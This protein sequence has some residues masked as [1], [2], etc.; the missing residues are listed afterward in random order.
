MSDLITDF[1]SYTDS[2]PS[3]RLF[4][5]WAGIALVAGALERRVWTLS[6]GMRVYPN[7]YTLL[8]APP[9]V[10]KYIIQEVQ[11]LWR[12]AG[13]FKVA[14]DSTSKASLI[15]AM[16][17]SL[18]VLTKDG[19]FDEYH[20]LL[21]A[22]EEFGVLVPAYDLDFL[23]VLNKIYNNPPL[24]SEKRRSINKGEDLVITNPQLNI[25][26]GT[27]PGYLSALFPEEAWTMGTASRLIMVYH[28]EPILVDLFMP[29]DVIA[30]R[31][32]HRK[33]LVGEVASLFNFSGEFHWSDEAADELRRWYLAG[34][35]PVP[36][37]SKL[38]YYSSRRIL[39]TLKLCMISAASRSVG[40]MNGLTLERDDLERARDWL[41]EAE[42]V[43]PDIF[44]AMSQKSDY[45][46]MRELH[47]FLWRTYA[48]EKKAIHVSALSHFLA[49][50]VPS[51]K[52][53]RIISLME[54]SNMVERS[55]GTEMYVPRNQNEWG[56]E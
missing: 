4:R 23:S 32:A 34:M 2:M 37:H 38:T 18:T 51:E 17:E 42:A 49:L 10:G 30:R 22:S 54:R 35:E 9:G 36:Q 39:H 26:A 14:P 50:R 11:D 12:D 31:D 47:I 45:E 44:R 21:V 24:H 43:M 6:A 16:K 33:K 8:V 19:S 13:K 15:D 53:P 52:V 25:F 55:A 27:Q 40:N 3:P 28:S 48:V 46:V 7:L 1:I 29:R 56:V 41:L 5:Q 20:S